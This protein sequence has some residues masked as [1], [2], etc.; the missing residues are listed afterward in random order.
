LHF[1][2]EKAPERP[3]KHLI[4][5]GRKTP[6]RRAKIL[7]RFESGASGHPKT[8]PAKCNLNTDKMQ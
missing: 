2:E 6:R 8:L 7:I 3:P 4:S 5:S 1:R